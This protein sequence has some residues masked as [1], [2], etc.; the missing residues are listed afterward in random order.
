MVAQEGI[1]GVP[2]PNTWG[3][4]NRGVG[5]V[6]ALNGLPHVCGTG[7]TSVL[8]NMGGLVR[9]LGNWIWILDV[10]YLGTY[11]SILVTSVLGYLGTLVIH[12]A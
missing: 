1:G 6:V 9:S 8:G 4:Q 11:L 5:G 7:E 3:T 2:N 12:I 10:H